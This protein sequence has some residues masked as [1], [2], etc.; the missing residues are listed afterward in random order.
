MSRCPNTAGHSC[1]KCGS[2]CT[3]PKCVVDK[4][5]TPRS[6]RTCNRCYGHGL[7][8][9]R[10]IE[11]PHIGW[12][13]HMRSCG[14]PTNPG[15]NRGTRG[16]EAVP[17]MGPAD[18]I[19]DEER[20][21][22]SCL[23]G[24]GGFGA[25]DYNI[26]EYGAK[27]DGLLLVTTKWRDIC[28]I[29]NS[30]T[31]GGDIA[32]YI[33]PRLTSDLCF[34]VPVMGTH[35]GDDGDTRL[36][37]SETG[38][39]LHHGAM[40]TTVSAASDLLIHPWAASTP[41]T[42]PHN[43]LAARRLVRS[44]YELVDSGAVRLRRE[45]DRPSANYARDV[46]FDYPLPAL[47]RK[48]LGCWMAQPYSIERLW[49]SE[50]RASPI[51]N[52]PTW[53]DGSCF[54]PYPLNS[55]H[56]S[57]RLLRAPCYRD[58]TPQAGPSPAG[59]APE[60][61]VLLGEVPGGLRLHA[62]VTDIYD[63]TTAGIWVDLASVHA[64]A[65]LMGR[66]YYVIGEDGR[67]GFLGPYICRH[68]SKNGDGVVVAPLT[69]STGRYPRH[70]MS[71]SA[72]QLAKRPRRWTWVTFG[73]TCGNGAQDGLLTVA[74]SPWSL[75][76]DWTDEGITGAFREPTTGGIRLGPIAKWAVQQSGILNAGS[77]WLSAA[78]DGRE[79]RVVGDC[80]RACE[81]GQ[82]QGVCR[83]LPDLLSPCMVAP[84]CARRPAA[85]MPQATDVDIRFTEPAPEDT[86]V[87][88]P[89]PRTVRIS[90]GQVFSV[91]LGTGEPEV[92][93]GYDATST[94]DCIPDPAAKKAARGTHLTT[95]GVRKLASAA[96]VCQWL[97]GVSMPN[98]CHMIFSFRKHYRDIPPGNACPTHGTTALKRQSECDPGGGWIALS[99]ISCIDPGIAPYTVQGGATEWILFANQTIARLK[100]SR[101]V[102]STGGHSGRTIPL[103]IQPRG[104]V[105][106]L[107]SRVIG[108]P[109]TGGYPP[110]EGGDER[111]HS[112]RR[113]QSYVGTSDLWE[114]PRRGAGSTEGKTST[115]SYASHRTGNLHTD[116]TQGGTDARISRDESV[117][118]SGYISGTGSVS[119]GC[120][121]P[122]DTLC[123]GGEDSRGPHGHI[124]QYVIRSHCCVANHPIQAS[125]C[126]SK[127]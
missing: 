23:D 53:L 78:L 97:E 47:G 13:R 4:C 71:V 77:Y 111:E 29:Y 94:P 45:T 80:I 62:Y 58:G 3:C 108:T 95:Q 6:C 83:D 120:P 89:L 74:L 81:P 7:C 90:E 87:T 63:D 55:I 104:G 34:A 31:G 49:H 67:S 36:S 14:I 64:R 127:P 92:S 44:F 122:P 65:R 85:T 50:S 125:C 124:Y 126:D 16:P 57:D 73:S 121:R 88:V 93:M 5:D 30:E 2:H 33:A 22:L 51:D 72:G 118:H 25:I 105:P 26:P 19:H 54:S 17:V 106:T 1:G 79:L 70:A 76:V 116:T 38:L 98:G 15:N 91:R 8:G 123:G 60:T 35:S 101:Y 18:A 61:V 56:T 42:I 28:P 46:I 43:I 75:S 114:G 110:T 59:C 117:T 24:T 66:N 27:K 37:L 84:E 119:D 41:R 109:A 100:S 86:P 39:T 48:T 9:D 99:C 32:G 21:G 52:G 11:E 12:T 68:I 103:P 20:H 102:L 82:A 96:G 107:N 115:I 40:E 113:L 10:L 112:F 69:N